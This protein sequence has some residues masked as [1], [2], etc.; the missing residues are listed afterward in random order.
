MDFGA[1]FRVPPVTISP[2]GSTG[3]AGETYSLTCSTILNSDSTPLPSEVPSP[4]FEWFFGPSNSSLPSGV[5]SPMGTTFNSINTYTSTLQFS[6]LSQSHAGMYTCQIGPGRLANHA[7][8]TVNG[9]ITSCQLLLL[10]YI[11][12]SFPIA[13]PAIS[14]QITT[15]GTPVL[16]QNGYSLTCGVNGAGNLNAS[17]TYQWNKNNGTQTQIQVEADPKLLSSPLR[18]SDA[19]Q[20]TCQATVSSLYLNDNIT[21]MSSQHDVTIQSEFR[22][23]RKIHI[24]K[25]VPMIFNF[26]LQFQ[27]PSL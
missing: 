19:G 22:H 20:Y 23:R 11:D 10:S 24:D 21:M 8:V 27:L 3:T 4:T 2:S 17:I 5:T 13:A 18:L 25:L 12:L 1:D 16:G 15:S 26:C 7:M 9:M 6:P 14:V